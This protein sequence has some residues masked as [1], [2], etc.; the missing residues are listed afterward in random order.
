MGGERLYA[1]GPKVNLLLF[2]WNAC[3]YWRARCGHFVGGRGGCIRA[4]SGWTSRYVRGGRLYICGLA[5]NILSGVG[6]VRI[7]AGSGG[8]FCYVG[9]WRLY[10]CG[11]A[12]DICQQSAYHPVS[13]IA[14]QNE[15]LQIFR[16]PA[17]HTPNQP[18]KN[19]SGHSS[20][21]PASHSLS[22]LA[23]HVSNF[24]FLPAFVV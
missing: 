21:Q 7:R 24:K 22:Q 11:I 19:S 4:G 9:G 6:G 1:C 17:S 14:N 10:I 16:P 8:T 12:V 20:C 23:N 3:V 18:A 15:T 2:G 5:V 13:Q